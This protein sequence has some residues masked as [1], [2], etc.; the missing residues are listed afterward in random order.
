MPYC[1]VVFT[2]PAA[3]RELVRAHQRVC[4]A[5]LMTTAAESLQALAA[6]IRTTSAA[7]LA[8]WRCSTPGHARSST[9]PTFTSWC[10][11]ARSRAMAPRGARPRQLPRAGCARCRSASGPRFLARVRARLPDVVIPASVWQ[12]PWVVYCKPTV[13]GSACVLRY[14]ARYV[15]RVGITDARILALTPDQVTFRYK[16]AQAHAP[17]GG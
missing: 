14:L 1:H 5:A 13:Q 7:R 12:T 11:A 3:L 15:H 10:P 2:L 16:D 8:S 9:I 17:G 4:L 6:R